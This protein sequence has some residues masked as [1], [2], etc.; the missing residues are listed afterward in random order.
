MLEWLGKPHSLDLCDRLISK[1]IS[2]VS[3]Y[4]PQYIFFLSK[5]SLSLYLKN[6]VLKEQNIIISH[7]T[8]DF[9]QC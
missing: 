2:M 4:K 1:H 3:L 5:Q 7:T 6:N 8:Q 9:Q